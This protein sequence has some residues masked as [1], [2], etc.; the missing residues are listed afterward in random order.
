MHCFHLDLKG[1][2][3]ITE[4]VG[5]RVKARVRATS[6]TRCPVASPA[7]LPPSLSR[8]LLPVPRAPSSAPPFSVLLPGVQG[9]RAAEAVR[10]ARWRAASL[11]APPVPAPARAMFPT[12][13]P[14]YALVRST[15]L[16]PPGPPRLRA[17]LLLRAP[18][19]PPAVA[20]RFRAPA[21]VPAAVVDVTLIP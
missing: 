21:Y 14:V 18:I 11:L 1:R 20:I 15:P 10:T 5:R 7:R 9:A 17:L 13:A 2:D 12:R 8:M 19:Y 3:T 16:R 4:T 6:T